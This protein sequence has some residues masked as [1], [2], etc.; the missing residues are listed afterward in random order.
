MPL[1]FASHHSADFL[2]FSSDPFFFCLEYC[3]EESITFFSLNRKEYTNKNLSTIK[4]DAWA[5]FDPRSNSRCAIQSAV[6]MALTCF[7][8][9][10]ETVRQNVELYWGIHAADI[11]FIKL[12]KLRSTL[13]CDNINWLNP[14]I[15][16]V[17]WFMNF[18][19]KNT[20]FF[21]KPKFESKIAS[22]NILMI[23][24]R[25]KQS[26]L[27]LIRIIMLSSHGGHTIRNQN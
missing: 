27:F 7:R 9:W 12:K 11:L 4:K 1:V 23:D 25:T 14:R 17:G 6:E 24:Y 21:I 26:S 18:W 2:S 19:T 5:F 15:L 22:E 20:S 10:W 3:T 16:Q 13:D 8:I